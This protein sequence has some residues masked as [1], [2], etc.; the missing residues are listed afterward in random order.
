MTE[1]VFAV[2]RFSC[3]AWLARRRRYLHDFLKGAKQ[4]ASIDNDFRRELDIITGRLGLGF[5]VNVVLNHE[6]R[7]AALFAGDRVQAHR[8]G[9]AVASRKFLVKTV[10][11]AQVVIVNTYPFDANLWFVPWGLWPLMTAPPGVTKVAIADGWQGAGSHRLKPTELSLLGRA[12]VR[13]K[14]LRPR[15]VLKQARHLITSLTRTRS[16]RQLEFLLVAPHISSADVAKRFSAAPHFLDWPSV[17]EELRKRHG[18]GPVKVAV[19]PCKLYSAGSALRRWR[20][21]RSPIMWRY[22]PGASTAFRHRTIGKAGKSAARSSA[23]VPRERGS[24]GEKPDGMTVPSFPQKSWFASTE[25]PPGR[26]REVHSWEP[27]LGT[28]LRS[29]PCRSVSTRP[30]RDPRDW[31]DWKTESP[32]PRA[33]G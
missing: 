33:V 22:L 17:L 19:T 7:I 32:C 1:L 11:D 20:P 26:R 15:H 13:L 14:T 18:D 4:R 21:M 29:A 12:F 30:L 3:Q 25:L 5:I 10:D 9:V 2:P 28:C 8:E 31:E 16:R 27:L 23:V 6:R 24:T